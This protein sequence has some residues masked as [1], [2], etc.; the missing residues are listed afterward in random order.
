MDT[1]VIEPRR[2]KQEIWLVLG[3]SLGQSAVYSI[4]S[5]SAK[6]TAGKPLAQQMSTLNSSQSV[7]PY[8]DLTYQLTG[9]VFT[10]V[11]ALLAIWL[12]AAQVPN[13]RAAL[14]LDGRQPGYDVLAALGL[15]ALIG[16]PGL[17]LYY[18]GRALDLTTTIV[19]ANL[20][21]YWWTVPVLI[22]QAVKNAF[23]EE[24]VAVGY[25]VTR[26]KQL[27][28]PPAAQVAASALLRGSYHLYQGIGPFVG[29]AV[30]GVVF[31]EWFR[32]RQRVMP[33]FLAHT[34]LDVFAFVGYAAL[35]HLG[36]LD[37]LGLT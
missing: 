13:V 11:P 24:V 33:L 7:R 23:L 5:L 30:M 29:N 10:I 35:R 27:N 18:V 15:T 21:D 20:N 4:I 28:W 37:T 12:L 26:L 22:L 2:L 9:I 25:L 8:L 32:R 6:L 34:L 1:S 31:A 3:L 19:P 36:L 14:G 16:I 17:G